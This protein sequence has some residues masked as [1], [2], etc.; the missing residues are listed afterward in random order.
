MIATRERASVLLL[1]RAAT[2]VK[3]TNKHTT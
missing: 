1:I 2:S 3:N